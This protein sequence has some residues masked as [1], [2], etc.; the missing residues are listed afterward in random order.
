VA[1]AAVTLVIRFLA[2][3]YRWDLPTLKSDKPAE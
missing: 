1:G 2:A 3:H